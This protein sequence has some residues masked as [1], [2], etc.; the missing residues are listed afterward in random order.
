MLVL[1]ETVRFG[2]D[3][4]AIAALAVERVY[5]KLGVD[6][7]WI[8]SANDGKHKEGSFHYQNQALDFRLHNVPP[9]KRGALVAEVRRALGPAFDVL[10]EAQGSPN[11]H[12]HVE[13]DP[14]N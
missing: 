13:Y 7:C 10:H 11:E 6:E 14:K 4:A 9:H 5:T 3:W 8:T 12:L 2:A 1:K